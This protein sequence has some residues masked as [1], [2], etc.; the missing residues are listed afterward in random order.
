V[1]TGSR[2]PRTPSPI[3]PWAANRSWGVALV[4]SSSTS[5]GRRLGLGGTGGWGLPNSWTWRRAASR[6]SQLE[7]SRRHRPRGRGS[8]LAEAE[9]AFKGSSLHRSNGSRGLRA[10]QILNH[11]LADHALKG[12]G[13]HGRA[14]RRLLVRR[15]LG[16]GGRER[17]IVGKRTRRQ[18]HADFCLLRPAL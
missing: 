8:D 1:V 6:P 15:D 17:N 9:V 13:R 14:A 5:C 18:K 7:R 11:H 4:S 12:R 2:E 16:P 3:N 10:A